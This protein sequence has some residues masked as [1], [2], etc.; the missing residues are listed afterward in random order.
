[1][2]A[3]SKMLKRGIRFGRLKVLEFSRTI[4]Y[5]SAF[6]CVCD[7]GNIVEVKR[8]KLIA[9]TTVSCGC[10]RKEYAG[11]R[12][13][14]QAT[15]HGLSYT[16]EYKR[17]SNFKRRALAAAASGSHTAEDIIDLKVS[18]RNRCFY[19]R[20]SLSDYHVDHKIPLSRGGSDN[21][22][23][24]CITCPTCNMRKHD[25]TDAEF[26]VYLEENQG[27]FTQETE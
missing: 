7:C 25:R 10:Y 12:L 15:T 27:R 11:K 1:M 22:D 9:R 18:Q 13:K 5:R 3:R 2:T 21:K 8:E 23:N 14:Q 24:L 17:M 6:F 20:N 26:L 4:N 19:C 16:S